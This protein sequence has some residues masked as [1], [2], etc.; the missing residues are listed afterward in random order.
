MH[1]LFVFFSHPALFVE[2]GLGENYENFK[3]R[4]LNVEERK[5][6]I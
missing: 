1:P 5:V 3:T 2:P 4:G 6:E